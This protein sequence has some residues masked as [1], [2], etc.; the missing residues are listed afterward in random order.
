MPQKKAYFKYEL[1]PLLR[2]ANTARK[3]DTN[4]RKLE[5]HAMLMSWSLEGC[6]KND[7]TGS[8]SSW[9]RRTFLP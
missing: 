8:P 2:N 4:G 6:F 7:H 1:P 3:R 9:A 5:H